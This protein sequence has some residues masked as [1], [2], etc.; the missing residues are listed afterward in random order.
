MHLNVRNRHPASIWLCSPA[1]GS[2]REFFTSTTRRDRINHLTDHKA[3]TEKAKRASC[4]LV[5]SSARRCPRLLLMHQLPHS[6]QEQIPGSRQGAPGGKCVDAGPIPGAGSNVMLSSASA[7]KVSWASVA[8]FC[9][10]L[11]LVRHT[12]TSARLI[13]RKAMEACFSFCPT[14]RWSSRRG[15]VALSTDEICSQE[16][17]DEGSLA[18]PAYSD[19]GIFTLPYHSGSLTPHAAP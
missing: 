8:L 17:A 3:N 18:V 14:H 16:M 13:L 6:F 9:I 5:C 2:P 11:V 4:L 12:S 10:E 19:S 1:V 15:K 7:L